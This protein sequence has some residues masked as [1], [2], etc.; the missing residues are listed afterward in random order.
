MKL[1]KELLISV[2]IVA[3][4]FLLMGLVLPSHRHL[5]ESV[6]TNRNPTIAYDFLNGFRLSLIHI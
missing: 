2:A 1:F 5:S 4:F 6:E 3:V